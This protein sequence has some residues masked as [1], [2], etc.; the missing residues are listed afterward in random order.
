MTLI[1][2]SLDPLRASLFAALGLLVACAPGKNE[3]E[4]DTVTASES[5]GSTDNTTTATAGTTGPTTTDGAT[6]P[7]T[8]SESGGQTTAPTTTAATTESPT[9]TTGVVPPA[10][11]D[12][13]VTEI[14]QAFVDPPT[15]S[16]FVQC[17]G[18][19]IHRPEPRECLAPMT[20]SSCPADASPGECLVDADCT[21]KPFG[22]CQLNQVFGGIL[23]PGDT[24]G[25]VYGCQTDADCATGEVCRCAGEGLGFFTE[26]V[27]ATCITDADCPGALCGFSPDIC[28]PGVFSSNCTTPNDLCAGDGDCDSPPC[29]F[30]SDIQA[31]SCANAACGRPFLVEDEAVVAPARARDDWRAL[32]R[33]PVALPPVRARLAAYW[34]QIGLCEHASVASFARFI[35]Q[36]LAV[37]APAE[38][39]DGAQKALADEV[40]HARLCF[41]LASL[42]QGTGVGPGPLPAAD[43]LGSFDLDAVLAAVIREACVGETLSALEAREAAIRAVDPSL[44]RTLERIAGDEQRH[45]ELGWR[46]VQWALAEASPDQRARAETVFAAAIADAEVTIAELAQQAGEPDLHEHGVIDAPLRAALWREGLREL[47]RPTLAALQLAA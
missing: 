35:L 47:V 24:C 42:Y 41:A 3:T 26:C 12:G 23:A 34:T 20:P 2:T 13:T 7:G 11:C 37:G 27:P 14:A 31:W 9:S 19:I 39:V 43:A 17:D 28:E 38:L 8:G 22:S 32:V 44:R 46:F 5:G 6:E 16:G 25:C 30:D 33:A 4:T 45:A 21:D 15:P 10:G 36:L 1:R 40:E 29:R 18:G